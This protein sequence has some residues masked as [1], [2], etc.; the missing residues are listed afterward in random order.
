MALDL[1]SVATELLDS[2]GEKGTVSLVRI[3]K[4]NDPRTATQSRTETVTPLSAAN[5]PAPAKLVG[6]FLN[7][8]QTTRIRSTDRM[9]VMDGSVEPLMDD[10]LRIDGKDYRI[11]EITPVNHAGTP[12][13]YK[14]MARG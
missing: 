10:L 4:V 3:D 6:G 8:D 7:N 14:V 2:L 13:I 9:V 5:L 12:Q 11:L 1:S